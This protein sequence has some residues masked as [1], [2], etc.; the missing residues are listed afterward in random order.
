MFI[1]YSPG[2]DGLSDQVLIRTLNVLHGSIYKQVKIGSH[3]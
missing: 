1:F 3:P 2:D